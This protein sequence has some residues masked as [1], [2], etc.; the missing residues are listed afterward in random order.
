MRHETRRLRRSLASAAVAGLF[1]LIATLMITIAPS[2][3][4]LDSIANL[5]SL[6]SG[7]PEVYRDTVDNTAGSLQIEARTDFA[8]PTTLV[9]TTVFGGEQLI[10]EVSDGNDD[11]CTDNAARIGFSH[12]PA[13]R[14][15]GATNVTVQDVELRSSGPFERAPRW[16]GRLHDD[17]RAGDHGSGRGHR[18]RADHRR[19]RRRHRAQ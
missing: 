12:E 19:R 8:D 11:N 4:A 7:A 17:P 16:F 10:L 1:A 13:V 6:A 2:A 3:Q 9:P 18:Q 5:V 14:F 15:L